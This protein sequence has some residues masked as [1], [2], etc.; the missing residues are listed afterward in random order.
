MPASLATMAINMLHK[1]VTVTNRK[2]DMEIDQDFNGARDFEAMPELTA[3][4][5]ITQELFEGSGERIN[6]LLRSVAPL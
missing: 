5:V 6:G 3:C 4:W 1:V 2:G